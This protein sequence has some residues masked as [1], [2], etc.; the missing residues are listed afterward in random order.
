VIGSGIERQKE[1]QKLERI[2]MRIFALLTIGTLIAGCTAEKKQ[3][4]AAPAPATAQPA[5]APAPQTAALAQDT[6]T[7]PSG[8]K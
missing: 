8:L 7:T 6:V 4:Q 2:I 3:T 5:S 1:N